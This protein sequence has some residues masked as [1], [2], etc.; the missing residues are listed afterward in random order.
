M[1][2]SRL[3]NFLK[4]VRGNILYV[5]P[6]DLDATDSVEN[7]GNSLTRP[8]KTI[9]RALVEASR[10]SYQ[11]GLN[12]DRF[13]QTTILRYPG[14][15]VV[16]NRPGWIPDGSGNFRDRF[17]STSSD[18]S[19]WD[20]T[21]NFELANVNNALYKLNS[22]NGGVIIPRGTSLVGMDL[23]K[24]RIRP[25]YVPNPLN[26]NVERSA[27]F[28][29]TGGC[30]FWQ[31][32]IFDGDPNG[33]VYLDYTNS[34][35]APDFSHHK[36]TAFEYADGVNPVSINDNNQTW[37]SNTRTDLDMYY[38]KVGLVYGVTSGREIEP[39]YPS[40]GLDIQPK[41]DE[42]RIVGPTAGSVGISSIKAGDGTT[43]ST[44]ITVTT[45]SALSGADVDTA[46]HI[47]G[48]TDTSYNGQF[49]ITDKV[50]STQF[51]YSVQNAPSD[52]LPSTSG[53]IA[54]LTVDTVSSSSPYIFNCSLRSVYGMCGLLADGN[55]ATGF[56]SM[57]LSQYTGIGLQKDNNAFL[58]YNATTGAYDDGTVSGNE[59]LVTDSRA[60]FKP[61]Y[62][63]YHI[64]AIND[65]TIQ[66]ASAFA[67]GYAEHFVTDTGGDMS[68][69]NS[70]SNF[71]SKALVSAGYKKNAYSQDDLG[72]ITHVIP[73]KGFPFTEKTVEF[74]A[75]DISKIIGSGTTCERLYLN[76]LTNP[77]VKPEN[78]V[79]GYRV[80]AAASERL[81]VLI[82][83]SAGVS[84]E[85][86]SRVVMPNSQSS[87]EKS[88]NVK[89]SATGI[90]SVTSN[91]FELTGV[92]TFENGETV[93]VISSDGRLPDGLESNKIYY[94]ITTGISTN[95]GLKL[96]KTLNDADNTTAL[97]INN[98]G[99][100]LKIVSRVSD[101]N[102][103]DIG[104]PIQYDTT[105]SQ[106]YI[107]VGIDTAGNK[108]AIHPYFLNQG[109][110]ILGNTSPRTYIKRKTDDRKA[111]DTTYRLRYVI[112]SSTG[113][114][115]ARPPTSGYVIQES[116][117]SIGSTTAEVQTYFGSGSLTN[118]NQ[119]R[120]F[121]LISHA[122]WDST[123][124]VDRAR[125]L[126]EQPHNLSV[127]S[128]VE[129]A[130]VK[131]GVNTTGVGNSGFNGTYTVTGITS[132][133]EFFVG[134]RT[135]GGTFSSDTTTRDTNLPYFKRK[136]YN[137][138]YIV[139]DTEEVQQ[140][141]SGKQDGIYY[142]TALKSSNSPSVS[143]FTGE[144]FIQ[145]VKYLYPQVNRDNPVLD[146]EATTTHAISD[147]IGDVTVSD[148][149]ESLTREA[150]NNFVSDVRVGLGITQ[151]VTGAGVSETH[152]AP[153]SSTTGIASQPVKFPVYYP[154]YPDSKVHTIYTDADH[155]L[156][157]V[158]QVSIA[159]SGGGYGTGGGTE[160]VY[161]NAQLLNSE[162]HFVWTTAGIGT[163]TGHHATAKVTV[164]KNSGGITELLIMNGG[165]AYGI[166]NT[167]YVAGITTHT[168]S[169]GTGYSAAK[170]TVTKI[171]N[172][173][174]N[175]IKL[176]GITSE[177]YGQY[178][179]LYRI[180]DVHVG[181]ARS[182]TA[183][184][185]SP[186]TGVT[187]AGIGSVVTSNAYLY[188]TGDALGIS[189]FQ[190]NGSSGIT[191]VG[192]S[193]AHGLSVN[194]KVKVAISTVGVRTDGASNGPSV[195]D[196][197][198][199]EYII[200]KVN[201][202]NHFE[203]NVG[204]GKTS[205]TGTISIGSSMFIMRTGFACADGNPTLEDESINGR[206]VPI[207]GD[208]NN[209]HTNLNSAM[210]K[211]TTEM[212]L[213][214]GEQDEI[215]LQMGDYFMIDD[216]IVRIKTTP[217]NPISNPLY[218][219]RSCLGTKAAAHAA[220]AVVRRIRPL[221]VELRRHSINRV[222]GHTFEYVGF[223]PGNYSTALPEKQ[224][225]Q[226]SDTEELLGQ[227]LRKNGG[228]NYFTGMNDK[229]IFYSGNKKLNAV[230]GKEEVFNTPIRT[231]TG[232][233]IS[234]KKGINI[235]NAT[236]GD[237]SNSI[238]VTGGDQGKV[239][240]EFKGPVV[241]SNKITS[242]SSRG[243]EANHLFLQGDIDVS[244]KFTISAGTVAPSSSGTPGDIVLTDSPQG[245][246]Y[247][248]WVYTTDKSWNRFGSISDSGSADNHVFDSVGVG[249]TAISGP[250][251]LDVYYA[252]GSSLEILNI[253][254]Y[255]KADGHAGISFG[256]NKDSGRPKAA[257][258]F[259]ETHGAAHYTG[260]LAFALN[261]TS[262]SATAVTV[263]DEKLRISGVGSVGVGTAAPRAAVDLWDA[264]P[265]T[266]R[267]VI[268]PKLTS[269]QRG[270][271]VGIHS[272]ALIYNTT[273]K[274]FQG[275]DGSSWNDLH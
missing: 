183:V 87:G 43:S 266:K 17:G 78:V 151:I 212:N 231:V 37:S 170:I 246:K 197:F 5:S 44:V 167:L 93:R 84:S 130:N 233:D 257:I 177:T 269:T 160:E 1:G 109:T 11:R 105:A 178:N 29:V 54:A 127:G 271:L 265:V 137:N 229:G 66:A 232:E 180:L 49:V 8:F 70:N 85:F 274:K 35:Y 196:Y 126:T 116:N 243:I 32:S 250:G 215:G 16:D 211:T 247:L 161:Y 169:V 97:T 103:G 142:I 139:Q 254:S 181:A 213:T 117:T 159:S 46:V 186:I 226:I 146:P 262:G 237:F 200:S 107:K 191:S 163:T 92:H 55:K 147:P 86:S 206:M 56:K 4:N 10:F 101:K 76:G 157:P 172:N 60:V 89:R 173:I 256:V 94:A 77:S 143:P 164:D 192:V 104:H 53:G 123:T 255:G 39:D 156:N 158:T 45:T 131:S 110:A 171:Y 185:N 190:Y 82:P 71:G 102:S 22:V 240:S 25:K 207:A 114:S 144:K 272:G 162:Q 124:S 98:L 261:T 21:T 153:S 91:Q 112:P 273:S 122:N 134:M 79:D 61:S 138:S 51:K 174:G 251:K 113:G 40:T 235:V 148:V 270:N 115:V 26:D 193:T 208:L 205:T 150:L 253:R 59:S 234:V 175:V 248:G 165:S 202:W 267:N 275:Y 238:S 195:Q 67:I 268:L 199:G 48:L 225:R 189:T 155:G 30:Y 18:F 74:N 118:V 228:I 184:G 168:S 128:L 100:P 83:I 230:T 227:S 19:A 264:G 119:Q 38:E 33:Q 36:L 3:E 62:Y 133:R 214:A 42:Y 20:L 108:D 219:F 50:N 179:G 72:Y 63:N 209:L 58:K 73:P 34:A 129:I 154:N 90:N 28:R 99:G 149:R 95:I 23:R 244:R 145:P 96:A 136:N 141:V 187:T 6:N 15:H 111:E 41:I 9:Q 13:G 188:N 2:L 166:G 57:V 64:K 194:S 88:F 152:M 218:V 106:W 210:T 203:L 80:G 241:F 221:P 12:N 242:T 220:E 223:G 69:T 7:K 125:Y 258:F 224:T 14:D 27:I 31:F 24:T 263:A 75:L 52:A 259:Q 132:A 47:S 217:A 65:A 252:L 135:D 120:N 216:E 198:V 182:F 239:I 176:A 81:N 201:T 140:Y 222:A 68:I 204:T 121:N 260:D 245:G 236:E 249:T